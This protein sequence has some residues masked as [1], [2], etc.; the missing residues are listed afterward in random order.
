MFITLLALRLAHADPVSEGQS[1][2]VAKCQACHGPEGRGDG[3]A[4]R[5]LPKPPRDFTS[6]DFWVNQTDAKLRSTIS[7]GKPGSAMRGF[8][9][10]EPQLSS[11]VAY[12]QS[13]KPASPP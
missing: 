13:M 4:A 7:Q 8:T 12:L 6:A 1:L 9:M 3:P 5:A 11:L 10:T 2:Y